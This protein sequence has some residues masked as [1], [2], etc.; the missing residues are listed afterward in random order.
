MACNFLPSPKDY[1]D[2]EDYID[3][4]V[5]SCSYFSSCPKSKV[6]PLKTENLSFKWPQLPMTKKTTTSHADELFCKGKLL[7]LHQKLLQAESSIIF[8]TSP[9]QSCRESF[10]LN[11]NEHL[12]EWSSTELTTSSSMDNSPK[13]VWSNKL[14][15]IK[16]SLISQKF[17]VLRAFLKSLFSKSSCSNGNSCSSKDMNLS[18]KKKPFEI[19]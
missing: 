5:N 2:E 8:P 7:P 10:E 14:N 11:S 15:L 18:K 13:K 19:Y 17:K 6:S 16:H 4:E 9:S 12:F 1:S 3:I